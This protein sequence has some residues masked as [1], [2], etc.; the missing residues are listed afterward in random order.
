MR[1]AALTRPDHRE[2][3]IRAREHAERL[4]DDAGRLDPAEPDLAPLAAELERGWLRHLAA[5]EPASGS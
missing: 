2:I 5:A 1:V 3:A 4:L